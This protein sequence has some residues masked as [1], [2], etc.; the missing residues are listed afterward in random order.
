MIA[1][2]KNSAPLTLGGRIKSARVEKQVTQVQLSKACH[3]SQRAVRA[4][5]AN[6]VFFIKDSTLLA[7]AAA[8]GVSASWL[9]SGKGLRNQA[10]GL[11]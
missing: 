8:L 11:L 1:N 3:I 4:I 5:E 7:L 10:E 6:E 9:A 2:Y